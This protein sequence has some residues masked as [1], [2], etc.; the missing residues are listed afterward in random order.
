MSLLQTERDGA[1]MEILCQQKLLSCLT[2]NMHLECLLR[3]AAFLD[4]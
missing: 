3:Q 2:D 4:D 1:L